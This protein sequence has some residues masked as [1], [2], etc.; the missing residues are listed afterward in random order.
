MSLENFVV[1]EDK[2]ELNYTHT[3]THTHI[4]IHTQLWGCVKE[5]QEPIEKAPLAIVVTI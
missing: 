1:P 3:H 4:H 2:E 5:T